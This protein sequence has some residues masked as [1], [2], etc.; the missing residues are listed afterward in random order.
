[1][2]RRDPGDCLER[3]DRPESPV[4]HE[5]DGLVQDRHVV[6]HLAGDIDGVQGRVVTTSIHKA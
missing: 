3:S 5:R 1:M 6:Q 4:G 2:P